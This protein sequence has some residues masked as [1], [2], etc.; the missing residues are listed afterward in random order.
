MMNDNS[1]TEAPR[2]PPSVRTTM[3]SSS[4]LRQRKT[5]KS[6]RNLSFR[7]NGPQ[8]KDV[9]EAQERVFL[10]MYLRK[11]QR[12]VHGK[13]S[14]DNLCCEFIV[15][16]I[17]L[18][19]IIIL[20][21]DDNEQDTKFEWNQADTI[22]LV[23]VLIWI[24]FAIFV[25][26]VY[27]ASTYARMLRYMVVYIPLVAFMT[28]M[29]FYEEARRSKDWFLVP[30]QYWILILAIIA[31][32]VT[33]ISFMTYY[34]VWPIVVKS[35]RFRNTPGRVAKI[36]SMDVV[37]D[38]T[39][40][41]RGYN[42]THGTAKC[43]LDFTC[44]YEGDT[45]PDTGLPDGLGRW[46]D[47]SCEGEMLTGY[48]KEGE[49][50][51]PFSSWSVGADDAV[52]AVRVAYFKATD[53]P[54]EKNNFY[55]TND[56]NPPECGVASVECSVSG[57][58]YKHLPDAT[59]IEGPYIT[60]FMPTKQ[61]NPIRE[62]LS[63]L[64]HVGEASE[65]ADHISNDGRGV[66]TIKI[67]ATDPRG[68]QVLGH[69]HKPTGRFYSPDTKSITVDVEW[70]LSANERTT[71]TGSIQR[72]QSGKFT[73]RASYRCLQK[74]LFMPKATTAPLST[75]VEVEM[76]ESSEEEN[77]FD[78]EDLDALEGQRHESA[79]TTIDRE[80]SPQ[81]TT[82]TLRVQNWVPYM[83]KEALVFCP[84]Y[85]TCMKSALQ[86]LG[87][88]LAM[89]KLSQHVYPFVFV[90]PGSKNVGFSL[91]SKIAASDINQ[92][93]MLKLVKGLGA[94]GIDKVHFMTHSMG[95]Q[96]LLGAFRDKYDENGKCIGRSDVSMC[97]QLD[98][99]FDDA[100]GPAG[101][102]PQQSTDQMICKSITMLNP[103]FPVKAFVDRA[104]LSIRRVCQ[105]ITL[106]GDRNDRALWWSSFCMGTFPH[107]GYEFP[108]VLRPTVA[109]YKQTK[110]AL[111]ER[112]GRSIDKLY[113]TAAEGQQYHDGGNDDAFRRQLFN[114]AESFDF[115]GRTKDANNDNRFWLDMDVIDMTGLDTNIKG[116]RHSGFSLNGMLL[117]DLAELLSSGNRAI[118]RS[119]LLFREGN[120][121][122]YA[123]APAF[124]VQ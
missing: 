54:F 107:F 7:V 2:P 85:N 79:E 39:M 71:D 27:G 12:R 10:N 116:M 30:D 121:F 20:G 55:P 43:Q 46:L 92:Q 98:P 31:E 67:Q 41:Y 9:N 32:V 13:R 82:A 105:T 53:D 81:M 40:K 122:S 49:P 60:D 22:G 26:F 48:W 110:W 18:V 15:V 58:F 25:F 80:H 103:D 63:H 5:R 90:W 73:P 56:Q 120:I 86:S 109:P 112:T 74:T 35:D 123:H 50:V 62:V 70:D 45:D 51:A 89:T 14:N 11:M 76:E 88:F 99:A 19:A 8:S 124:V 65:D 119:T 78:E 75:L 1:S 93:N 72:P 108:E 68:I 4:L 113:F 83:Y 16:I 57:S 23:V 21:W 61:N 59:L 42:P 37:D 44:K 106:V 117:K 96:T 29:S 38:W 28:S 34:K 111:M 97:F 3:E 33:F 84:G 100:E 66:S 91:A 47:D 94:A 101:G 102:K 77:I 114:K 17:M 52:V 118:K 115:S 24:I 64:F 36:W 87:Q 95:A 104:F 69:V 6:R